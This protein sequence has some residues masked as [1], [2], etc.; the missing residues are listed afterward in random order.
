MSMDEDYPLD[1]SGVLAERGTIKV[2]GG[3]RF[4]RDIRVKKVNSPADNLLECL[5]LQPSLLNSTN[6]I[7][8]AFLRSIK[9]PVLLIM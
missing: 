5:F 2:D 6:E 9:Y 3:Y 7:N 8:E 1:C 4:S